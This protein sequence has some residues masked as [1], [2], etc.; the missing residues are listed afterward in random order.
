VLLTLSLYIYLLHFGSANY[1]QNISTVNKLENM[2]ENSSSL[3]GTSPLLSQKVNLMNNVAKIINH[4]SS[5]GLNSTIYRIENNNPNFSV[6]LH[7][8]HIPKCGG[9]SMTSLLRKVSCQINP[10]LN[11]DCCINPGFCDWHAKRRCNFIKGCINHFP[12]R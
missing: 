2:S 4:S 11:N 3:F 12:Q 9:T 7:F 8:I 1:P 6:G 10:N 5:S